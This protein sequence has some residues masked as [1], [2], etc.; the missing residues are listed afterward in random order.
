ML[1]REPKRL[2][3]SGEEGEADGD[4]SDQKTDGHPF[5]EKNHFRDFALLVEDRRIWVNREYLAEQSAVFRE[6]FFGG[7]EENRS[8]VE[9]RGKK[10]DEIVQLLRV[11]IPNPIKNQFEPITRESL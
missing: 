5:C 3:T 9:L 4:G 1:S 11:I 6:M 7:S 10:V 8:E 2:H